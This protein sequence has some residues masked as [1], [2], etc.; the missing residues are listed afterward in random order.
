LS[1]PGYNTAGVIDS[2]DFFTFLLGTRRKKEYKVKKKHEIQAAK[3]AHLSH[4]PIDH[5]RQLISPFGKFTD[6]AGRI[7]N[8]EQSRENH[9]RN[10]HIPILKHFG[11]PRRAA[12]EANAQCVAQ[13]LTQ[14][15]GEVFVAFVIIVS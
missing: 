9:S 5:N 2:A 10:K 1:I 7:P 6:V 13:A 11:V 4:R 12:S 3:K 14:C 8:N 15:A